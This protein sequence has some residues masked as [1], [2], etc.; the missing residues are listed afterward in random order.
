MAISCGWRKITRLKFLLFERLVELA[1]VRLAYL[2]R[3]PW[4]ELAYFYADLT[5]I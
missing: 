2:V 4:N 3:Q 1:S 5:A